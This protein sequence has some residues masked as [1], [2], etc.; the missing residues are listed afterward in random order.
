MTA[1]E[2][3]KGL[4][5]RGLPPHVAAGFVA[6]FIDESSLNPYAP[7]DGGTSFG[8]AQWHNERWD[9]LNNFAR[10]RRTSAIDTQLDFVMHELSTTHKHVGEKLK[11]ANTVEEA[12]K[13]ITLDYEVPQNKEAKALKRIGIAKNFASGFTGYDAPIQDSKPVDYNY[14]MFTKDSS[15]APY[16]APDYVEDEADEDKKQIA[17]K[18][19]QEGAEKNFLQEIFQ[20]QQAEQPTQQPQYQPTYLEDSSLFQI[21]EFQDGGY[22]NWKSKHNL[23]ETSDYNLRRAYDLG[24]TPDETGHLP[25]VD[26]QT[27]EWLKSKTHPTR[28]MELQEYLLNPELQNQ[29]NLIENERGNLQ[30]VDR[31]QFQ[32][33]GGY[34]ESDDPQYDYVNYGTPEYES[35]Y[36]EGRFA[37]QPNQ[38]DEV[39]LTPYDKEYPYYQKL[40][41]QEKKYFNT[42]SPIGRQ[43]DSKARTGKGFDANDAREF[44]QGWL[45]DLPLA[46]LQAPQS[47]LT[48]GIE[49]LRGNEYNMLNAIE[50][51]KQRTPSETLGFDTKDVSWYHPKSISNFA[52]DAV[53]DPSLLTGAG[54]L[55]KQPL[56]QLGKEIIKTPKIIAENIKRLPNQTEQVYHTFMDR[57]KPLY[58]IGSD[59]LESALESKIKNLQTEEGFNRLV[60]QEL[61]ITRNINSPYA[62]ERDLLEKANKNAN[63][64]IDELSQTENLNK[65]F[66]NAKAENPNI[67][68]D[69]FLDFGI[70]RNNAH[71]QGTYNNTLSLDLLK[72]INKGIVLDDGAVRPGR[73]AIGREYAEDIGVFDHEIN[74]A[75]Q[76]GRQTKIDK[77]IIEHFSNLENRKNGL[78]PKKRS[79]NADEAA[80]SY[81]LRGSNGKEPSSFLAEARRAML[82][83]G[84]IKDIYEP[85]TPAI[86]E[87]SMQYFSKN[88]IKNKYTKSSS[89]RIFDIANKNSAEFIANQMNKLPVVAP[90]AGA[91][92]LTTQGAPPETPP[93]YEQ[94]GEY[95]ENEMSFLRDVYQQ[96]GII[97]DDNGYWNPNNWGKTVEINS[98]HIT[99]KGV[100]VPLWG[101]SKE[102]GE[103]KKMM[104]GNDY[105]FKNTDS[106]IEQ[107]VT[108]GYVLRY[109]DGGSTPTQTGVKTPIY[110]DLLDFYEQ[111][112]TITTY[113]KKNK[114]ST[115]LLLPYSKSDFLLQYDYCTDKSCM[116]RANRVIDAFANRHSFFEDTFN[117]TKPNIGAPF[118]TNTKP[119]AEQVKQYPY[120]Q[121]DENSGS[122]DSWDIAKQ[123]K[124][125]AP[126][127]V[128][129]DSDGVE[130]NMISY[131]DLKKNY[132]D[133]IAVGSF[134]G[135]GKHN[136]NGN[137][138]ANHTV[139]VVGFL[140]DGE[141]LVA[142]QGKIAP[143]N[144]ALYIWGDTGR[145]SISH[146]LNVPN[147]DRYTYSHFKDVENSKNQKSGKVYINNLNTV[148]VI[149]DGKVK[150]ITPSK[151][152]VD[153]HNTISDGKDYITKA[154][155]VDD[156]T[157]DRYAKIALTLGANETSYGS[158]KVYKYLAPFKDSKGVAQLREQNVADKYK[159]TLSLYDEGS[160]EY[161]AMATMLYIKELDKYKE[162]WMKKGKTARERVFKAQD[163]AT[164]KNAVR[165]FQGKEQ[166]GYIS[167]DFGNKDVF[168][169]ENVE[170]SLPYKQVW[171][172]D[173][174]YEQE[175]NDYLKDKKQNSTY[176]FRMKDGKREMVK[177]TKGTSIPDTLEDFVF[178]AWQSPNTVISGDAQG[179][180]K[181][182]LKN[183]EYYNLLFNK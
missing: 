26:T 41:S 172:S 50:P 152:Y 34:A 169:D 131:L 155:G 93:E 168:K 10:G 135:L 48:E 44:A 148:P 177:K 43:I 69:P 144:E 111:N 174:D 49:A 134:I 133:K 141:P 130:S 176:T 32:V 102:T 11:N 122:L 112:K 23:T 175:V 128:V 109:Q 94:G 87:K 113:D 70:P 96:G 115:N 90:I 86:I 121:G 132:A 120:M 143:L 182:Y 162:T 173:K 33:G 140:Q 145:K 36:K 158:S 160:P 106:V 154:L 142:D 84:L 123:Y 77:D 31:Q 179:N 79:N 67:N 9:N 14:T 151:D 170:I 107:P 45:V 57:N 125:N 17:E 19:K 127:S 138:R 110:K 100:G 18:Q 83:K 20:T 65:S 38:L 114:K 53:T 137:V 139:R 59:N 6:N 72:K 136:D 66:L 108:E 8:L 24:Y 129:F 181:Y 153:F 150:Q 37:E 61:E 167:S 159:E 68:V 60:N 119:T 103:V 171:Q 104:P 55:A 42:D 81:L 39:V 165:H 62:R 30:Y 164:M 101:T 1:D 63:A 22:S 71:F 146:I 25:S 124:T 75:L 28:G 117:K 156:A 92:Y 161:N 16:S 99:M 180:S 12:T 95:T 5:K 54:L 73:I 47:A 46:G 52:L 89:T 85:I 98:P 13:I 78:I 118:S 56:R 88:P 74:H 4:I 97:K 166:T 82:N 116:T 21:G 15:S 126:K 105:Y 80:L 35:A 183:K 40:S 29:Y 51:G 149:Q 64:R 157:Y 2:I 58:K 76:N 3:Y 147:K 27:G 7:G 91:S 178:Y 163:E